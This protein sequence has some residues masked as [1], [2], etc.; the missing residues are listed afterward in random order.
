[1]QKGL[2]ET[3]SLVIGAWKIMQLNPF[4]RKE[5]AAYAYAFSSVAK[6]I[7]E[8]DEFG[9]EAA[10]NLSLPELKDEKPE[11]PATRTITIPDEDW[12]L[13]IES[14][15]EK[16][17]EKVVFSNLLAICVAWTIQQM[18]LEKLGVGYRMI[19]GSHDSFAKT[20]D[21]NI[22]MTT[23]KEK[24]L[25]EFKALSTDDKLVEIYSLLLEI[26]NGGTKL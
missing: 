5:T 1:M 22:E 21:Y 15:K 9:W 8:N 4:I 6:Y 14:Y 11:Y 17:G 3:D 20:R 23:A 2:R 25:E 18:E 19:A 7:R 12:E 26:R 10:A 24:S 16:A 13:V